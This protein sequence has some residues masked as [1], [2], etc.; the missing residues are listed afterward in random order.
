MV[1]KQ[2]CEIGYSLLNKP[3]KK[4]GPP[5]WLSTLD[6]RLMTHHAIIDAMN[7]TTNLVPETR[8]AL[9][10]GG[11]SGL[12]REFCRRLA[13]QGWHIACADIDLSAAEETLAEIQIT[14]GSGQVEIFDVA[15]ADAW[16]ALVD[17][18][19]EQW[20]RLD[21]LVNNAGLAAGGEIG[22]A[23]LEDFQRVLDV[24]LRGV[25]YGCHTMVPWLKETSPGGQ[26]VNIASIFAAVSAPT[27]G[28]YC[29][30]KA[31]VL[32]LSETLYT[33]LRHLGIGVTVVMPGFFESGL[34]GRGRFS[35]RRH[36]KLAIDYTRRSTITAEDVVE[37]TF[38]AIERGKLYVVL[39]KRSRLIWRLKRLAPTWLLRRVASIHRRKT[40]K[41]S[42]E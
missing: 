21:M 25:L 40:A 32:S 8:Y 19:R 11:G 9:V 4:E 27:M 22:E 38:T 16:K 20:P 7:D 33:E 17:K 37:Q 23:P 13:Q 29:L 39:G 28:A 10:T 6:T 1:A 30:S 31:G 24:N 41:N 34:I 12:G 18:L 5:P 15:D 36:R 42:G 26:I 2:V 14:G 35:E 3:K